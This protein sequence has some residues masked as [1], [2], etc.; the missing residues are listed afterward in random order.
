MSL[1]TAPWRLSPRLATNVTRKDTFHVTALI[2]PLP[3]ELPLVQEVDLA[4]PEVPLAQSATGT[5]LSFGLI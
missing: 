2:T 1:E 3:P 4:S 5:C